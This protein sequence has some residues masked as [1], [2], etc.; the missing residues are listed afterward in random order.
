MN[1]TSPISS[2]QHLVELLQ[3]EMRHEQETYARTLTDGLFAT[4][5]QEPSCRYPVTLGASDYNALDQLVLTINY[6]VSDDETETDFEPGKPVVF[7][8]LN[9][10]SQLRELTHQCYIEQADIGQ[11][12]VTVPGK[13]ALQSIRATAQNKILGVRLCIDTTSYR[14]MLDAL[15]TAMRSDDE[16]FVHLRDTLIGPL[17]PHF[18]HLPRL[19]FP[20]LNPDQE[21]AVQHVIEAQQVAI[22]HGPPGTGKTATPVEAIVETLQR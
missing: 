12:T 17:K 3:L 18:R 10:D 1:I 14:V 15:S 7:F 11:L 16:K 9:D 19:S 5:V 13:S 4:Q 20:W 8:H 22:V 6:E 21:N 2:L